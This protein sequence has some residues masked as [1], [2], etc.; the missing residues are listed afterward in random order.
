M[1]SLILI[2]VLVF[3]FV[4]SALSLLIIYFAIERKRTIEKGIRIYKYNILT[5]LLEAKEL[6]KFRHLFRFRKEQYTHDKRQI[7]DELSFIFNSPGEK[8]LR[9]ALHDCS[10]RIPQTG[11]NFTS[12]IPEFKD[13][14]FEIKMDFKLTEDFQ[15]IITLQW[16]MVVAEKESRRNKRKIAKKIDKSDMVLLD[17][18]VTGYVI[19]NIRREESTENRLIAIIA[20]IWNKEFNYFVTG[21]VL[22]MVFQD[23]ITKKVANKIEKFIKRFETRGIQ[24]GV[25]QLYNGSSYAY[26]A[27]GNKP[28]QQNKLFQVLEF[29]VNLSIDKDIDFL[30]PHKDEHANQEDNK[31]FLEGLEVFKHAIFE[32]NIQIEFT[33]VKRYISNKKVGNYVTPKIKGLNDR[34]QDIILRNINNKKLLINTTAEI[35]SQAKSLDPVLVDVNAA[36]VIR[37]AKDL[38]NKKVIY[39]VDVD[40]QVEIEE[41]RKTLEGLTAQKFMFGL[42]ISAFNERTSILIKR[43]EIKFIIIDKKF[44]ANG[45]LFDSNAYID[46]LTIAEFAQKK[47]IQILYENPSEFIDKATSEKIGLK[48]YF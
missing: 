1:A 30:T 42:R 44:V 33:S 9:Q 32:K 13:Q 15:Y 7:N 35:V 20:S 48:Y 2:L 24:L 12:R 28:E 38:K 16:A 14:E 3:I 47:N 45:D 11:F 31:K 4:A 6:K 27:E 23:E 26:V 29:F 5:R 25:H 18:P 10:K 46:L 43:C 41:L 36:W 19:F 39:V 22:A 37:Y 17:A 34:V 21:G 40:E 8:L